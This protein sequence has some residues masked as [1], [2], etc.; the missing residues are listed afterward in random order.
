MPSGHVDF[1]EERV[2]V[3][4]HL[5]QLLDVSVCG[6]VNIRVVS[7][8]GETAS[9]LLFYLLQRL[10]IRHARIVQAAQG[11]DRLCMICVCL[12]VSDVRGG[13]R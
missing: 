5:T 8:Y 3:G 13:Y 7:V 11:K 1:E 9:Y 12:Y 2:V 6:V 10:P 4:L